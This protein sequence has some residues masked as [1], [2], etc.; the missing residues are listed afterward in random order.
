MNCCSSSA[1]LDDKWKSIWVF[2]LLLA[3]KIGDICRF[4]DT[5]PQCSEISKKWASL[6][7]D[8]WKNCIP[9]FCVQNTF[10]STYVWTFW[11]LKRKW[12]K[13]VWVLRVCHTFEGLSWFWG[14][15]R[16]SQ[17]DNLTVRYDNETLWHLLKTVA[18]PES[19][20]IPYKV[21]H[22]LKSVTMWKNDMEYMRHQI[23]GNH[24][25]HFWWD[26]QK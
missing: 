23:L 3:Q 24:F 19:Q 5:N 10:L 8:C 15:F 21:W 25:K 22:T 20:D 4:A 13:K 18:I 14:D 12:W 11:N 9:N 1:H 17:C 2:F 16:F 26:L 7:R 6:S